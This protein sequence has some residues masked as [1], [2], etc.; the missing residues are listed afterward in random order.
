MSGTAGEPPGHD[1][2]RAELRSDGGHRSNTV[3]AQVAPG[4]PNNDPNNGAAEVTT[5]TRPRPS[6]LPRHSNAGTSDTDPS[7]DATEGSDSSV[8]ALVDVGIGTRI[9]QFLLA[10]PALLTAAMTVLAVLVNRHRLGLDLAGGRLLPVEGLIETW[11]SYLASWHPIGGGSAA[12][13]PAALAVLGVLGLPVGSPGVAV[14]LLLLG[15]LPLAAL[16]AYRATCALPVSRKRRALAAAGYALLPP[17]IAGL[18]QGRLDVVLVH[19]LLPLVLAGSVAVLRGGTVGP[20]GGWLS[21]AAGTALG[22]AVIGAFAPLIHLLVLAVVLVGFVVTPAPRVATLRR[23]VGLFSVVLLPLGLLVPWPAV[24]IQRPAVL[25]HGVGAVVPEQV[26][27]WL[28]LLALDPGG[29]GAAPWVGA[30]VVIAAVI[31]L[32]ARP[33]RAMLPGLGLVLLGVVA[34]MVLVRS[35]MRPLVG[36]DPRPGSTAGALLLIGCGLLW[37]VLLAGRTGQGNRV[38]WSRALSVTPWVGVAAL[39]AAAV[40]IG[41]G[42]PLTAGPPAGLPVLAPSLTAELARSGTSVLVVGAQGE[43]VRLTRSRTARFGDDDIAPLRATGA[44]LERVAAALRAGQP[45]EASAAIANV[46]AAGVQFVVLPTAAQGTRALAAAGPLARPAPPTA[47]GR[48]VLRVTRPVP[49]AELLGPALAAQA[50]TGASP[51]IE[52]GVSGVLAPAAPPRVAV[53][54]APGAEGRLLVV[55]A[56]DEP[57]WRASVNGRAVPVVRG[58][59]HQV[60]VPVQGGAAEVRLDRSDGTRNALLLAECAVLLLVAGTAVP[61]RRRPNR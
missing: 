25:L 3:V 4:D 35:P 59:G 1:S 41:A 13:P 53:R 12:P 21:T 57:D 14:S 7:P 18:A 34:V 32:V 60:A 40:V 55:A 37:I 30:V 46:A 39:S 9:R 29:P 22:L 50:R 51:P 26:P 48:P 8:L 27:G 38:Q 19:L 5:R 28:R 49:G 61:S 58:W 10:P 6:P 52:P 54:V 45:G 56:N 47:D 31:A 20:S 16:S 24:V 23:A 11:S 15:A 17:A 44:R 2:A 33:S 36:G 42:G 43:P